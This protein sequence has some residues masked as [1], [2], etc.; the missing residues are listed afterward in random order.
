MRATGGR[1]HAEPGDHSSLNRNHEKGNGGTELLN[2]FRLGIASP[3]RIVDLGRLK[4]MDGIAENGDRLSIGALATLNEV[5]GHPL[6]A[7]HAAVLGQACLAAASAQ[8]RNRATIGGNLLQKTRCEYFRA[9][10]PLPWGCNKRAP[11]TGCAAREGLNE[12][13]AIFGWTDACVAVQ[14]SDPVVA[15]AALDAQMELDGPQG[16]RLLPVADF[17]LTQEQAGS[18]GVE[19]AARVETQL[20]PGEVIVTYHVPIR[21]GQRSS[22]VKVRE[23][24]SYEYALVSAAVAVGLVDGR[25]RQAAV[26]LGSVAQ[27]P[28]RLTAAEG[29]LVGQPPTREAVLPILRSA[30]GEARPLQH[31]GYKVAMA[32]GAAARAI[33]EAGA[34]A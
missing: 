15:L 25:I 32:A 7:Q 2:W 14:P 18:G 16:R 12:R 34:R 26:A 5:G 3:S 8:I 20:R 11:G 27:K 31:N 23:R 30:L 33:V 6:V 13:H 1:S 29:Q 21:A 19:A 17:H 24:A 22:Y 28:W 10:A 9:E 4:G